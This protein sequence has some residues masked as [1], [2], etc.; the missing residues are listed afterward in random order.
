M[1]LSNHKDLVLP[2]VLTVATAWVVFQLLQR[3]NTTKKVSKFPGPSSWRAFREVTQM[4]NSAIY[5]EKICKEF[6]PTVHTIPLPFFNIYWSSDEN[7]CSEV[8]RRPADF[9]MAEEI[10]AGLNTL[11]F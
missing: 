11:I 9:D 3:S 2:A 10:A 6:G 4:Q 5:S 8:L 1:E 7:L